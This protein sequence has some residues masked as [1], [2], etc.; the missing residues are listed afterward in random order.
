MGWSCTRDADR[1]ARQWVDACVAS[2]GSQNTFRSRGRKYFWEQSRTEHH[3]GA[4]T[5]SI[6]RMDRHGYCRRSGTFRIE[7]D[8]TVSRA[9]AFL[10]AAAS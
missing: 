2:T 9:P 10:R 1:T 5:G 7:G 6:Y 4:I 8:G 3:D